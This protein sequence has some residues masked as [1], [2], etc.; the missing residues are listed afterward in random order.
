MW[1]GRKGPS[2]MVVTT[3]HKSEEEANFNL[4]FNAHGSLKQTQQFQSFNIMSC[5]TIST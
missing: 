5:I 1:L 4:F 2:K 3:E